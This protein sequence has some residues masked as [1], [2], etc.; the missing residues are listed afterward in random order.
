MILNSGVHALK[1]IGS[2]QVMP[3]IPLD[4]Y[5]QYQNN[6]GASMYQIPQYLLDAQ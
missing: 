5:E 4:C 6:T 3:P 2:M 1:L